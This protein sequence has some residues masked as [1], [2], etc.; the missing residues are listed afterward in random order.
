M[1]TSAVILS[2]VKIFFCRILDVTLGTVRT[3]LTV[4]ERS[5][6]AALMGFCEVFLWYI[7]VKDALAV[8]E[9]V[10]PIAISYAAGFATGTYVGGLISKLFIKGN[11][12]VQVV[13]SGRSQETLDAVRNEGWAITVIDIDANEYGGEKYMIFSNIPKTQIKKFEDFIHKHDAKA[14]IMIQDTRATVG[15]YYSQ[16]RK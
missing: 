1:L 2:C 8:S 4:K 6:L 7:V 10:L 16:N 12:T 14:F 15:G 13:T 9:P 11:V 3:I 5:L